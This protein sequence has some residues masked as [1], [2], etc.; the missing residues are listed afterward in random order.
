MV[1]IFLQYSPEKTRITG[2]ALRSAYITYSH[3]L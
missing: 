3:E 2:T 1:L